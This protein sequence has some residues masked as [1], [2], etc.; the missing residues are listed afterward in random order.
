M[1]TDI[2]V[3]VGP[4]ET[5]VAIFEDDRLAEYKF[6]REQ[7]VVGNV[8]LGRVENVVSGLD[9]AF[10]DVGI[11]R[12]VF[13]HVSDALTKEPRHRGSNLPSIGQVVSRGQEIMV[14][15]TKGPMEVKGARATRRISL[16][17]RHLV[18]MADGKNKV[19]VSKKIDD[20][21]ERKR[22]RELGRKVKPDDFSLIIRTRARGADQA[23][24][25]QD[26]KFL[27][28]LW[29]SIQGKAQQA[30]AP[31][32]LSEDTGLIYNIVRDVFDAEVNSF[33]INDKIAYD[34]VL[35]LCDN[36]APHLRDKVELYRA[37]EPIAKHYGINKE[38]ERTLRPKVWLPHGGSIVIEQTEALTSI[39][40]NSGKFTDAKSLEDT[41]LRTNLEA[42]E[43]I[44]QQL[45]LRDIGGIIVIDFIDMD[46]TRHRRKVSNKLREAFSEDRMKTRIM[47]IT[48]LG[49]VEMTRKRTS[50]SI[51]RQL[52]VTCPC[53][54]GTG[55]ILS[56]ET[57]ASRIT[58]ELREITSKDKDEAYAIWA[59]PAA[60]MAFLGP[61]GEYVEE[62][63]KSLGVKLY[64]RGTQDIHPERYE[65]IPGSDSELRKEYLQ[66]EKNQKITVAPDDIV[67]MPAMGLVAMVDGYII[68]V[69]EASPQ[70]DEELQVRLTRVERSYGRATPL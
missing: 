50:P 56:A 37:K 11:D 58:D 21:K 46:K 8:Y 38:L 55:M 14:Q 6:E 13:L 10:V 15:V 68:D 1:K 33:V 65:I 39:D 30:K 35:N 9:A 64:V 51:N 26:V 28:K 17:S 52:Q 47:H 34:K 4:Q 67:P 31:A 12:N 53:C 42:C 60:T 18:L 57:V 32:L 69:P 43:E 61:H 45:R 40:V 29:R 49:L 2:I 62:L 63:E 54:D 25:E 3:D 66:F 16:P 59:D 20:E 44:A 23:D 36:V 41:V 48:R 24:F 5:K 19:G 70:T 7:E 27:M 22:L